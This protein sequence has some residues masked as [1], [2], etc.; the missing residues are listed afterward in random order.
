MVWCV[1]TEA[2]TDVVLQSIAGWG[3][4]PHLPPVERLEIAALGPALSTQKL[5]GV[6]QAMVETGAC[7]VDDAAA[8]EVAHLDAMAEALL[9]EDMLLQAADVL[10][11]AGIAWR[12]LKG[13]A[14]AHL[15]HPDP[16]QR[17]FGDI[18]LLIRGEEILEA[19][20]A[21]TRAGASRAQPALSETFDRRFSKSVT[22]HWR[23]RTEL[24]IHRTLAPGP[25]GLRVDAEDLFA[26][27]RTF[28]LAGRP[29]LTLNP[30][31]HLLH[32][33]IHVALGDV[34]PRFGNVRDIALLLNVPNLD[35]DRVRDVARSWGC[36]LP[37]AL[38]LR[39]AGDI[40][41]DGHPLVTWA[42]GFSASAPD[43]QLLA[44]YRHKANRF[45]AQA[46]ATLRVLPWRDKPIYAKSL[47]RRG[48][49]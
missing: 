16:A 37:L 41:A 26:Q 15:V 39:A 9:L 21:L 29:L 32:G 27:P 36:E 42:R 18:D 5:I 2:T 20:D 13:S 8:L 17:C 22:L 1:V 40:G 38:G 7:E 33:A 35:A 34:V 48:K 30:E 43:L 25:F 49:D 4:G 10:D 45:R 46:W 11:E 24:D 12:V 23:N 6:L 31:M 47:L 14:L 28:T 3:I 19:V 44:V